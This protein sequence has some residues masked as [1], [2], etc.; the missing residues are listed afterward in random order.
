MKTTTLEEIDSGLLGIKRL[1]LEVEHASSATPKKVDIKK[2]V[3]KKYS[4]EENLVAIRNVFTNFGMNTS[5]VLVNIYSN[6]KDLKFLEKPK[7][8]KA[9]APKAAAK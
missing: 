7:G 2:E 1:V 8:K 6:E 5:K 9:E 4:V 3:A